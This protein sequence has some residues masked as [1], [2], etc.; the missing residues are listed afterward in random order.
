MDLGHDVV[1]WDP[2]AEPL[3]GTE[4]AASPEEALTTAEAVIVAS[5]S[6]EHATQARIALEHGCHVLVEKPLALTASDVDPL[7][8]LADERKLVLGVAMNLRFHPA[9]AA[10]RD[11]VRSGTIGRPL[12]ARAW[13]GSWLPG[14]RPDVDYRSSYSARRELGGGVLADAIHEI[15]YLMWILGPVATVTAALATVS[16]LEID[17]EDVAQLQLEFASGLNAA[18]SLDYLDRSYDRGCRIVGSEGTL[19]WSWPERLPR[20]I[21]P[22]AV[23]PGPEP[24]FDVADTYVELV[25]NFLEAARGEQAQLASAS[26]AQSCLSVV[27]AARV[28]AAERRTVT[29]PAHRRTQP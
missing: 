2:V 17:V 22:G 26:E 21:R 23:T 6:S 4:C 13:F 20:V 8:P 14:W 27:D 12:V 29:I 5:P 25:R 3:D 24:A 10:L 19:V 28:S 15:D 1:A 7:I 18:V 9:L 16:E 11:A